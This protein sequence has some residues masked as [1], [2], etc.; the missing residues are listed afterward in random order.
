VA[1]RRVGLFITVGGEGVQEH[2][3]QRVALEGVVVLGILLLYTGSIGCRPASGAE[4]LAVMAVVAT[5]GSR[6]GGG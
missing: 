4:V 3:E 5:Q 6:G 2:G 1:G